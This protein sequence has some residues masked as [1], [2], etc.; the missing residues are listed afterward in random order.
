MT[1]SAVTLEFAEKLL[2][3]RA[4]KKKWVET[5]G[6]HERVGRDAEELTEEHALKALGVAILL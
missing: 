2:P 3:K 4:R 6:G 5:G 1:A